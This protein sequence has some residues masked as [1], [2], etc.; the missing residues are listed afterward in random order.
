VPDISRI[1]DKQKTNM[2]KLK[3]F[4]YQLKDNWMFNSYWFLKQLF[5]T[6]HQR[7]E[8]NLRWSW[9]RFCFYTVIYL[10]VQ[11]ELLEN[12][13]TQQAIAT[14]ALM[15]YAEKI[16]PLGFNETIYPVADFLDDQHVMVVF[17]TD[18]GILS[19]FLK[20][21]LFA[22]LILVL[23]SQT[24]IFDWAFTEISKFINTIIK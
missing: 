1:E 21:I 4:Y 13:E 12:P 19:G 20:T 17:R 8:V 16:R 24:I 3:E 22:I 10:E 18:L 5:E 11:P 14:K 6:R 2:K 7:K 15:K 9:F 23:H